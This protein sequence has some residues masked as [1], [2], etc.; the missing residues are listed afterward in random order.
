MNIV[1]KH[2]I[3]QDQSVRDALIK[4]DFLASDAILFVIDDNKQP[5]Q[6]HID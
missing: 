2:I 6:D 5:I 4:L 3:N 1:E